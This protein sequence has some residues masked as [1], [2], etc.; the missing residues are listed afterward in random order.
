MQQET[1]KLI[2][3][4]RNWGGGGMTATMT[5]SE[6]ACIIF[7][8]LASYVAKENCPSPPQFFFLQDCQ[9]FFYD[10]YGIA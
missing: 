8:M 5:I 1:A 6:H 4:Y 7:S 3:N 10:Y 2:I 9:T